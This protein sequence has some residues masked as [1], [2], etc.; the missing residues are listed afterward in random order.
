M[1]ELIVVGL[2]V[3]PIGVIVGFY[4]MAV[5]VFGSWNLWK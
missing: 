1:S 4:F 5:K 3:F 2:V